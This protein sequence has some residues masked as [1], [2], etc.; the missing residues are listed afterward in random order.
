MA[1]RACRTLKKAV[2]EV[3]RKELNNRN[4]SNV[5]NGQPFTLADEDFVMTL[6]VDCLTLL[7]GMQEQKQQMDVAA[8]NAGRRAS[9]NKIFMGALSVVGNSLL[10]IDGAVQLAHTNAALDQLLGA[11]S[12]PSND[13]YLAGGGG[14]GWLPLH[15]A[16]V[17]AS[18]DLHDVT[19]ADVE[20][21][22]SLNPMVIQTKHI[23]D[24]GFLKKGF[25]PALML[26]M[27]PVTSCSMELVRLISVCSPSAF[28]STPTGCSAL[29]AACRFGT[30]T[31]ELLQHLLQLDSSQT[32]ERGTYFLFRECCP[33]GQL[34]FNLMKRT[35]ELSNAEDLVNCLLEVDKSGEVVGDALFGSLDGYC[36]AYA[37]SAK[38]TLEK[39]NGRL[40]H[41]IEMLLKANPESAKYRDSDYV[42]L[43]Y[44]ACS[45]SMPS[46][47][48]IDIIK[49]VLA[50]HKDAVRE[51]CSSGWLPV[52]RAAE[53][54][55]LKVVELLLDLYPAA[56]N[57]ATP[58]GYS[59]LR[60]AV[61]DDDPSRAVSKVQYLC[62]RYPA[63][64][65]QRDNDGEV[66]L[67]NA[68]GSHMFKT[69][70][71]LYEA[72]GVEQFKTPIA[73]PT[74]ANYRL[75]GY[76]PLHLL[77]SPWGLITPLWSNSVSELA[78]AFRWLLRV[79]PDAVG[80]EGGVGAEYKKTPYQLAVDGELPD[81]YLRLLLRAAPTF[82]PA[83][84]HRLNYEQRRMAMFLAFKATAATL[85]APFLLARL[86]VANKDLVQRVV[87]FL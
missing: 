78:D 14:K 13:K 71:A 36:A 5:V 81:Y 48:C 19:K 68:T 34:C 52:H 25:A 86:R 40:C 64:M 58:N 85:Q 15:W 63:M 35:D 44:Q 20:T 75:N 29:H 45:A 30:P 21:L 69:A 18:A 87:S 17:L 38:P 31:V 4:D 67:H 53:C 55:D 42:N 23:A 2:V 24:R 77:I 39:R 66:P 26:C 59:L 32:K 60:F 22:Y 83:E 9:R 43:L 79:C 3:A 62:A 28:T 80:I 65:Q 50:V 82:K 46:K 6:M 37:K 49:L 76:L 84:L 51:L 7:A 73:H 11:F 54:F 57:A 56:V 61:D 1:L 27:S 33:L 47:L 8:N 16:V 12:V 72:G 70:L 41:M 10:K 74:D